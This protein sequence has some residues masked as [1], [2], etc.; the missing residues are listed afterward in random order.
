[1]EK[2]PRTEILFFMDWNLKTPSWDFAQLEQD[3]LKN[4]NTTIEASSSFVEQRTAS[5]DFSVDLKLG[6]VGDLGTRY[7]VN[8]PGVFKMAPSPSEPS[9]RARGSGN[10]AQPLSCLV[11]GCISD[12]S[13]YRD[14]H[15]RHKV[16]E[17]HSKTPQ[18]TIG[19]LKQRFCQQC[20]RYRVHLF[21]A[22][23]SICSLSY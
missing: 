17:L 19:G 21:A 11:D 8:E 18:V 20:S 4:I 7:V 10:G 12:L 3:A 22:C 23:L 15:R 1:M 6:Q 14:Y 16:C 13:N 9:K 5:G 2:E